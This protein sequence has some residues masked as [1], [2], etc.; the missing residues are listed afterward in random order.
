MNNYWVD[1]LKFS[2]YQSVAPH[3]TRPSR[4]KIVEFPMPQDIFLQ[5]FNDATKT[6]SKDVHKFST[7]KQ[8][9]RVYSK[10]FNTAA[11][12]DHIFG[13]NWWRIHF[14]SHIG[15]IYGN[16]EFH[17]VEQKVNLFEWQAGDIQIVPGSL[18]RMYSTKVRVRFLFTNINKSQYTID[19]KRIESPTW[20]QESHN[21]M[22]KKAAWK[23]KTG[24]KKILLNLNT[25]T[26]QSKSVKVN[27]LILESLRNS[28]DN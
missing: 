3:H 18:K 10:I 28:K 14:D 16:I 6:N 22:R 25:G 19:K 5:I 7:Y 11:D 23:L 15:I 13:A 9:R 24:N 17:L 20:R 27:A 8:S 2:M 4:N 26:I 1:T 21:I 12:L